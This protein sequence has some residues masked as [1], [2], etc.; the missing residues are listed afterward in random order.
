MFKDINY[1]FRCQVGTNVSEYYL[2]IINYGTL[3]KKRPTF[4]VFTNRLYVP[5]KV[6]QTYFGSDN[7]VADLQM[8]SGA[9]VARNTLTSSNAV[10]TKD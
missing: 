1:A 6:T 5:E 2:P 7:S 10:Y 9:D 8:V 3:I 4:E